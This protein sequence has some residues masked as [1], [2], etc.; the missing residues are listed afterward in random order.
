[1]AFPLLGSAPN[2]CP[3]R[4]RSYI[5][6]GAADGIRDPSGAASHLGLRPTGPRMRSKWPLLRFSGWRAAR[7]T[8]L[9]GRRAISTVVAKASP[10]NS[11]RFTK[12]ARRETMIQPEANPE[13]VKAVATHLRTLTTPSWT[14]WQFQHTA[15]LL[16]RSC[17]VVPR[18]QSDARRY[19]ASGAQQ[20]ESPSRGD[21]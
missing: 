10:D 14:L 3:P 1:M 17:A 18:Q 6:C 15:A 11:P 21:P 2:R 16:V 5:I 12:D 13:D 8:A 20:T 9:V 19:F 7:V 4:R